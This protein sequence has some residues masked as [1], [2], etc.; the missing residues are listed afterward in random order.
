[1]EIN[2]IIGI[3]FFILGVALILL[4]KHNAKRAAASLTW[5]AVQGT[6]TSSLLTS[7]TTDDNASVNY[8]AKVEYNYTVAGKSY[9]GKRIAFGAAASNN[10]Q[11]E[12]ALV[13]KYAVGTTVE[14]FYDP[15]KPSDAVLE[16]KPAATN[17]VFWILGGIFSVVGIVALF[18]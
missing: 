17:K 14:V 11:A 5:S 3:T 16:R 2:I 10:Q 13:R 7:F 1:M 6:V 15:A 8:Q 18:I 9:Q 12:E 4:A